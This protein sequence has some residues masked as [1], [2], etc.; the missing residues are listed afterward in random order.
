MFNVT[1]WGVDPPLT[2]P[3]G[4]CQL[5]AA[6]WWCATARRRS[7]PCWTSRCT[8]LSHPEHTRRK[9]PA[10]GD[11]RGHK[12]SETSVRQSVRAS[13]EKRKKFESKFPP[14]KSNV[15]RLIS[16]FYQKKKILL[17]KSWTF[18]ENI[19]TSEMSPSKTYTFNI[20]I[21]TH[22]FSHCKVWYLQKIQPPPQQVLSWS[23][24]RYLR[25]K[26]PVR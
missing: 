17:S 24:I 22:I 7:T 16:D 10:P 12:A 6:G 20:Y 1:S 19:N 23:T 18:V 11:T 14:K 3:V 4:A 9:P 13:V 25:H 15:W 8:R 5:A 26:P 21:I 2:R